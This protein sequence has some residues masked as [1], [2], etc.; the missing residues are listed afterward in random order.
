[1][2]WRLDIRHR[3]L[4]ETIGTG[5]ISIQGEYSGVA[6][7]V[8]LCEESFWLVVFDV[9]DEDMNVEGA[10]ERESDVVLGKCGPKWRGKPNCW[11]TRFLTHTCA[12]R[13]LV[14][15]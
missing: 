3:L 14:A 12:L 15:L 7:F 5:S 2:G 4:F 10:I 13:I 1:M 9:S 11:L 6:D 8:G